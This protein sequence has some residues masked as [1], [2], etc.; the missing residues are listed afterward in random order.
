MEQLQDI[1]D[2]FKDEEIFDLPDPNKEYFIFIDCKTTGLSFLM[3]LI[4]LVRHHPKIIKKIEELCLDHDEVNYVTPSGV[5]PLMLAATYAG[6]LSMEYI[7]ELLLDKCDNLSFR[8]ENSDDG[9][10]LAIWN[11]KYKFST[12]YTARLLLKA[13]QYASLDRYLLA[14]VATNNFE[15]AHDLLKLGAN[16]NSAYPEGYTCLQTSVYQKYFDIAKLFLSYN[17]NINGVNEDQETILHHAVNS[18]QIDIVIDLIKLNIGI[19]ARDSRGQT[20]LHKA[21]LQG[22]DKMVKILLDAK[23]DPNIS[24]NNGDSPLLLSLHNR[25]FEITKLLI[26][27]DS[28]LNIQNKHGDT[29]LH[30]AVWKREPTYSKLLLDAGADPNIPNKNSDIA[31]H[32]ACKGFKYL[33]TELL[34]NYGSDYTW[35]NK[36]GRHTW[37]TSHI[38]DLFKQIEETENLK[39]KTLENRCCAVCV[40]HKLDTSNIPS[41]IINNN[42][43]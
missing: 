42:S 43:I 33:H 31:L 39:R 3:K 21:I 32:I 29:P 14:S 41:F 18:N 28:H 19:N 24:D 6:S 13:G 23:A 4:L 15:I 37:Y 35:R 2:Q 8:T 22:T 26:D 30:I 10:M 25:S 1:V 16:P 5:T 9:L 38:N 36:D 12:T 20:P 34:L 7:V 17:A 27:Y 40:D 11:S